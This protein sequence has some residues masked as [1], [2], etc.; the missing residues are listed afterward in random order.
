MGMPIASIRDER[1]RCSARTLLGFLRPAGGPAAADRVRA[2][3]P[4]VRDDMF[5][6][7][8]QHNVA[9]LLQRALR[10]GD[11]LAELHQPMRTRL[12]EERRAT[13]LDNL[14]NYGQFRRIARALRERDIPV[15][16]LKGLHLAELVYRDISLRPMIDL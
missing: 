14:R 12:E 2:L 4:Q 3:P 6:L 8:L 13:A 16:G 10:A 7:A 1:L 11:A 5:A 15:I 9:P